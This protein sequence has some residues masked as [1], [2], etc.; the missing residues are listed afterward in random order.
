M[1]TI[2]PD[3]LPLIVGEPID[4]LPCG[5]SMNTIRKLQLDRIFISS[6]NAKVRYMNI[7][8]KR[9]RRFKTLSNKATKDH[10]A[11]FIFQHGKLYDWYAVARCLM[12]N[13]D[14]TDTVQRFSYYGNNDM[15]CVH[16]CNYVYAL[17]NPLNPHRKYLDDNL[18][19]DLSP[20]TL[21]DLYE[22]LRLILDYGATNTLLMYENYTCRMTN[23]N[24]T[25]VNTRTCLKYAV[26][27]GTLVPTGDL[28]PD[29][30][31]PLNCSF[32]DFVY[33]HWL[34]PKTYHLKHRHELNDGILF[35]GENIFINYRMNNQSIY[36]TKFDRRSV[37]E[38]IVINLMKSSDIKHIEQFLPNIL[39]TP[40]W[41]GR[42]YA[43]D[44]NYEVINSSVKTVEYTM[45]YG[46]NPR[47]LTP[48]PPNYN[49]KLVNVDAG[50]I[51]DFSLSAITYHLLGTIDH[52]IRAQQMLPHYT[53]DELLIIE[54]Y[55]LR[56]IRNPLQGLDG[57]DM[58]SY[59]RLSTYS[60]DDDHNQLQTHKFKCR[61]LEYSPW[62][63]VVRWFGIIMKY[64]NAGLINCQIP[65][66]AQEVIGSVILENPRW[67]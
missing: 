48:T 8:K 38:C 30:K 24:L 49:L 58:K 18:P 53:I 1:A 50:E 29:I 54:K 6:Q 27:N 41:L 5:F 16:A 19:D 31:R 62:F 51:Q 40:C 23:C 2:H 61:L 52:R 7:F 25:E 21:A 42:N 32:I 47:L 63:S 60:M 45:K 13:Y 10:L 33:L 17:S 34:N 36:K 56:Y 39:L 26:N 64:G 59:N 44:I 35:N 4:L 55:A 3:E 11:L 22:P 46:V 9:A 14:L 66:S 43:S 28:I 12:L 57:Y 15:L 67:W 65:V 37:N 20:I